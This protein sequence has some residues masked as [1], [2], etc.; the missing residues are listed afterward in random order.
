MR[1]SRGYT[2]AFPSP[3]AVLSCLWPAGARRAVKVLIVTHA[4][5]PDAMPRAFRWTA[6]AEH[7]AREGAAVDIVTTGR[8]GTTATEGRNR[9]EEHTSELPSLMRTSYAVF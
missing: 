6:I 7:W 8:R 4:Y 5:A 2:P 3:G 1:R 9:S